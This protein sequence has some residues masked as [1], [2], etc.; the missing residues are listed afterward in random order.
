MRAILSVSDK[1]GIIELAKDLV[2]KGVEIFS[3]GGTLTVLR[4]AD[5]PAKSVTDI[6]G[7]PE[8]M[9][10]RV[11]TLHPQIHGGILARRS[12][13]DDMQEI[14]A[15][16]IEPIDI[17]VVNLYP[18]EE[19]VSNPNTDL[20]TAL[21]NIDIGGPT[22]IRAAAK[23]FVDVLVLT[24]PQD[25]Q[26]VLEEWSQHGQVSQ[27]T[28]RWLAAKAFAHVSA[29]D[30]LINRYLAAEEE[31]FPNIVTIPLR[32]VQDLVYGEN[33][34]QRAALYAEVSPRYTG[35]VQKLRQVGG[36]DLSFN[37][38][39]DLYAAVSVVA[40]FLGPTV[41]IIKHGIPCG[42]A[43]NPDLQVAFERALAGDPVS[44]FGGIVGVNREIDAG[45]A[46]VMT[47]TH[48]DLI[49]APSI[50]EEAKQVFS[51][52]RR[53]RLLEVGEMKPSWEEPLTP[54]TLDW[55]RING[56]FLA[57]TM[58]AVSPD[59][60]TTRVVTERQPTLEETTDLL[61][62]W[63]AVEHV[64]SNAIVLAKDLS[65][66]GVGSGQTSRVDAVRHAV[67]KAGP[68]AEGSVMAS[69]AFFPFPDGIEEAAKGGVTAVIQPGG[70]IRDEE[71]IRAAN[72]HGIAMVF[73]GTRHFKH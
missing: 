71:V 57:Q 73:T 47:Q 39:L 64:R 33:P 10:G 2:S 36:R 45:L 4:E 62:A 65:M 68:R 19:T 28:R 20:S 44:A 40:D 24:D 56:G 61:F 31:L 72:K 27:Q 58:D 35:L 67:E 59:E 66:V 32:K 34:H 37:N 21:E 7:F 52:K 11:K 42:L 38:I 48:F 5:I 13:P 25:Y 53:L 70:S 30:A 3:T 41:T 16:G 6:T 8:I 54:W 15:L 23:N 51:K 46:E 22:L 55:R 12:R 18:F 43:T 69:D 1:T 60:V 49:V 63:R 50:T 14:A 9:E 17:V 29:Y 26:S